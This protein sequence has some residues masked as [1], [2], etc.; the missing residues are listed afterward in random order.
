[1][2]YETKKVFLVNIAVLAVGVAATVLT[3]KFL[4]GYLL[5]FVIGVVLAAAVKRP[6]AYLA[7]KS[8]LRAGV[9]SAVL[10]IALYLICALLIALAAWQTA[11][12]A[13]K[14]ADALP[15]Y[16][17]K[18]NGFGEKA[19]GWLASRCRRLPSEAETAILNAFDE[20]ANRA[21]SALGNFLT[22]TAAAAA[23]KLPSVLFSAVITVVASCYI[24]L[25]SEHL[26]RFVKELLPERVCRR[27]VR[28]RDILRDN[29]FKYILGYVFLSLIAFAELFTGFLLLRIKYAAALAALTAFV[30]LLPVFG[31]GTVLVP[32]SAAAFISGNAP[33]AA[34][35]L[36]LYAVISVVRY[37]A[38]PHIVGKRV[39]VDPLITLAAMVI[40]LRLGGI[41]G[42][43][44]FPIACVV[45]I[46][47]YRRQIAQENNIG[48]EE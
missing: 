46:Q 7:K 38:E 19:G 44:V 42:L 21:V 8:G 32:W 41:V 45:I 10:V 13:V 12:Q 15:E 35:L 48:A 11:V 40:G 24:A 26:V 33:L 23:G 2:D 36:V 22:D 5:P 31:T 43:L 16:I 4:I 6:A 39:G 29:I 9:W 34:G 28:V 37:F 20:A 3:V 30:D 27:V 17:V 47:Y 14:L 18:L 1:M 25:D